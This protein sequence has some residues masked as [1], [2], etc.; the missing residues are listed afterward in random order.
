ME[1]RTFPDRR[2]KP[3]P[4]LSRH[5]LYG[6]RSCFR[7]TEDQRKGGY[8]DR[9][10]CK[11]FIGL[12]LIVVLNVL[13]AFFTI[14]ILENGGSEINPMFR[15]ALDIYGDKVWSLKLALVSCSAIILCL[16]SH[17][18][19]AKNSI[20]VIAFLYSGVVMYQLVLLRY[21]YT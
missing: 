3:T 17:F 5:T 1:N 8:V 6:R 4:M 10:D 21:I 2:N 15:W 7:R 11:L 18:R 19:L 20:F 16:H 9:Y 13:D 12:I 14:T